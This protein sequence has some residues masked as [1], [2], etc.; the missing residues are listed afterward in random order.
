MIILSASSPDAG[1]TSAATHGLVRGL[2]TA[3]AHR[4]PGREPALL[5]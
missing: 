2:P 3:V 4:S 5:L 1:P